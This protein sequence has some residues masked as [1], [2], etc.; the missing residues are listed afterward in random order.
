MEP[1]QLLLEDD[2]NWLSDLEAE[3]RNRFREL[4]VDLVLATDF[5]RHFEIL[6]DFLR[7]LK[8]GD[9]DG[10]KYS[11]L[12]ML[13]KTADLRH[14]FHEWNIHKV[15][16][17]LL[18]A[19]MWLQGDKEK[20]MGIKV[21]PF[22]DRDNPKLQSSQAGFFRVMVLDSIR[23]FCNK[24]PECHQ[25]LMSPAETNLEHWRALEQSS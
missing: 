25:L 3:E 4:V 9:D 11:S 17:N 7:S 5:S 23:D 10:K 8:H 1:T 16:T 19:E 13:V 22:N 21:G 2:K 14:C 6:R 18:E 24:F 15:W 12:Q 20:N